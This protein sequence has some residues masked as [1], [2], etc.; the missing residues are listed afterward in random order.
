LIQELLIW[1]GIKNSDVNALQELYWL[2]HQDLF[3]YGKKMTRD[4][5]LVEDAI[6]ETFISIWKYREATPVPRVIKQYILK[7]FRNELIKIFKKRS[8][9]VYLEESLDFTFEVAF[10]HKIIKDENTQVLSKEINKALK[11]LTD[12][13]REII[14]YRFYENL[15]FEE[16]ASIMNMQ[17][18]A[19]YKLTARALAALKEI[20]DPRVFASLLVFWVWPVEL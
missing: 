17:I 9:V 16:I 5:S 1:Q 3:N 6:Q 19:T 7:I 18:R 4:E 14:Y 8:G 13:Q 11:Q 20:M 2:Y 12:R 10:D 15:S